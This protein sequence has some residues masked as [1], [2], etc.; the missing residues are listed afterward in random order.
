[1]PASAIPAA[2][3]IRPQLGSRPKSA[4]FTSGELAIARAARSASSS[5]GG[6]D[7]PGRSRP[8]SRPRRRR[9]SR[10]PAAAALRRASPPGSGRPDSPL[11]C[12]STVSL[13]L[14]W[15]STVIR[16]K[17]DVDGG[18]QRRLGVLDDR[19][20]LH[21]AEHRREAGL[22]HPGALRLGREGDAVAAHRAALGQGVGGH[23]RLGELVAAVGADLRGGAPRCRRGPCPSAAPRRFSR[24]QRPRPTRARGRAP[25]R[26][27]SLDRERVAHPLLARRGVGVAGLDG[28]GAD[29]AQVAA[30][31]A[32]PHRRRGGGVAGQQ[33][34]R[35][36]ALGRRD[37]DRRRRCCRSSFSPQATAP[38]RETRR[39]LRRV[40]LLDSGGRLDPA[41]SEEAQSLT[42]APPSRRARASG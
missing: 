17:E 10:A 24:S 19:V 30:F 18:P 9:R 11:A 28:S 6:L 40:E 5:L 16:S 1:M 8:G 14:I 29:P 25:R 3:A 31:A 42:A 39:Q 7:A 12:S 26:P 4:V 2:W 27:R 38:A 41:R 13:V 35:V 34:R 23:D 22:D 36:A 20:G 33:Q 37:D 32:E 15:P 21:E